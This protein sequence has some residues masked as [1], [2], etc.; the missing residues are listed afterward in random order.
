MWT[1]LLVLLWAI[2][3]SLKVYPLLEKIICICVKLSYPQ[4]VDS[5]NLSKNLVVCK[6]L[7]RFGVVEYFGNNLG[8]E[9]ICLWQCWLGIFTRKRKIRCN[10]LLVNQYKKKKIVFLLSLF[11]PQIFFMDDRFY[12]DRNI[13]LKSLQKW[14]CT[15]LNS[16][17]VF[18]II[19]LGA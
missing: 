17:L 7:E 16:F 9:N 14:T 8:I 6:N 19:S 10:W 2:H 1:I 15:L 5:C 18:L 13:F 11:F 4:W 12:I 3:K